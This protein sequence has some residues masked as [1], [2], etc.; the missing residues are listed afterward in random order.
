MSHYFY[1]IQNNDADD[2]NDKDD[3]ENDDDDDEPLQRQNEE[4]CVCVRPYSA[5]LHGPDNCIS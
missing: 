4:L 5:H 3:D 2:D 1:R